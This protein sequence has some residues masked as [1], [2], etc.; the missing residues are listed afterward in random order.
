VKQLP[1]HITRTGEK[2]HD[3]IRRSLDR[4]PLF[5]GVIEGVGP[6]YCPSIEDKVV[7]F[8]DRL[9]HHVFLEPEGR[10]TDVVYANGISTSL[11]E[12]VQSAF[13]ATIPGL[14]KAQIIRPGYAIEYDYFP[15]TQLKP[16]LETKRVRGLYF[17]GQI[18]GTSGYEEAAAQGLMAGINASLGITGRTGVVFERSR[19]YIGVMID[20]LVTRGTREPYRMFTSRAEFRLLLRNDNADRRLME[21]GYELGLVDRE[22]VERA[23]ERWARVDD[24]I[25]RLRKTVV[26]LDGE[27]GRR[28]SADLHSLLKRPENDYRSIVERFDGA[29]VTLTDGEIETLEV[30][31]KYE[32]YL[33]RQTDEV[34]RQRRMESETLPEGFEPWNTGGFSREAAEKLER[35]RPATV[36]Q[37]ARIPGITPADISVLLVRL[38]QYRQG[39]TGRDKPDSPG[40]GE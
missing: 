8:P 35:V 29:K 4:S 22:T 2:T 9:S 7:R 39:K 23:R 21:T 30:S 34:E 3:V 32:G 20:D 12:D 40:S 33:K 13:I 18:N 27:K 5:S 19:A 24:E 26:P 11:P 31:V 37:A 1:C 25:K 28:N 14:E 15:P 10:E 38:T 17:A 6:R 16:T 36:G